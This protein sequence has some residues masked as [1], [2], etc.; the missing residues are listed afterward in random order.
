M[1]LGSL[2]LILALL[3]LVTLYISR[4]F[5]E[6]ST[7]SRTGRADRTPE[8]TASQEDHQVSSLLAER[9]RILNALEELDFDYA[10][11][12]IPEDDYPFQRQALLGQGVEVLR[13]LDSVQTAAVEAP[14]GNEEARL[15]AAIEARRQLRAPVGA[16]AG[17]RLNGHGEH[18]DDP[19]EAQIA[20]RRRARVDKAAGFCPQCGG[21]V[22]K[23]DAFCPR[24]GTKL[25]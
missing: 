8:A 22:Q 7:V 12:K 17:Q 2:F 15:E 1:D 9:D 3:A 23:S 20:S 21:P 14:S 6:P 10:V 16:L 11:G 19:I 18:P 25:A 24:C 13:N 4:P 5:Y